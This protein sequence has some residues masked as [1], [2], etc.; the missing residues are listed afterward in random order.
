MSYHCA[1][2]H[3]ALYVAIVLF[4]QKTATNKNAG[5]QIEIQ[6]MAQNCIWFFLFLL[7]LFQ[8]FLFND[9]IDLLNTQRK[10]NCI[11]PVFVLVAVVVVESINVA[12]G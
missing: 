4:E 6:F 9:W 10:W 1:E 3:V 8:S 5:V 2:S 7:L 12:N 11:F